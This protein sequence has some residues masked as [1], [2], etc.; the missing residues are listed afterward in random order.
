VAA[1]RRR[2]QS[3]EPKPMPPF[4]PRPIDPQEVIQEVDG[5]A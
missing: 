5:L 4:T 2:P 3:F 1:G